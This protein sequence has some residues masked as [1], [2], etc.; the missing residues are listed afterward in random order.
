MLTLVSLSSAAILTAAKVTLGRSDSRSLFI[1][2]LIERVKL[3][4]NEE[5]RP[6][7]LYHRL[8]R[9]RYTRVVLQQR[10]SWCG[11]RSLNV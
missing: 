3:V 8:S 10:Q 7:Q 4:C 1:V 9:E 5:T 2:W 11:R 6:V